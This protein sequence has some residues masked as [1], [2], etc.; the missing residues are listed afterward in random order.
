MLGTGRW[1]ITVTELEQGEFH[2]TVLE[3]IAY[4]GDHLVYRPVFLSDEAHRSALLAWLAG[5]CELTRQKGD[6]FEPSPEGVATT[7][8]SAAAKPELTDTGMLSLMIAREMAERISK[9]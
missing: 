4:D 8:G 7:G 6:V 2:F 9:G 1:A 5:V 3:A